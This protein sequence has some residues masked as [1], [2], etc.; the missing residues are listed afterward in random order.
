[1]RCVPQ[2]RRAMIYKQLCKAGMV[3]AHLI[4]GIKG[5]P[6]VKKIVV[7]LAVVAG[8]YFLLRPD[9]PAAP[10]VAAQS[11]RTIA[12]G[13]L[14]GLQDTENTYAWLGIPFAASTAGEGRWRKPAP[15]PA[16]QGIHEA[17]SYFPPCPQPWSVFGGV[18]GE[19]GQV[20]GSEDCLGLNIWAPDTATE[21][22][23]ALP[24]MV[25]I[26]GGSNTVGTAARYPSAELAG[27]ENVIVVTINYRLGLLGWF[28]HG[29]LRASADNAMDLSGNFGTLDTIAALEWVR[30]NIAAFGGNPENV[31]VFGESAGG[32]NVY[33]L[34]VSPLA[35][36]LF[37]RAIVQS[38]SMGSMP[39]AYGENYT[40]EENPGIV[41]SSAETVL[42]L[43][44]Q[45]E[46]A[47]DRDTAKS[48]A[49]GMSSRELE[50]FL[51]SRSIQQLLGD[52]GGSTGTYSAP[53]TFQDGYV[54]PRIALSR[55]LTDPTAYNSVPIITGSNRDE[56][57]LFMALNPKYSDLYFGLIPRIKDQSAFDNE[58][59]YYSDRWRYAAVD[60]PAD[61][62][63]SNN[64]EP[65]YA[66]RFDWDEGGSLGIVD[67][68]TALGAAHG[69]EIPFVLGGFDTFA[70]IPRLFTKGNSAARH[71]LSSGMMRYWAQFARNGDP[72]KGSRGD[73]PQWPASSA[74]VGGTM[75]LD[76]AADGGIRFSTERLQLKD[77]R[78]RLQ[79]DTLISE[80]SQ[81]CAL[82]T[83][84]FNSPRKGKEFFDAG[85][86]ALLGCESL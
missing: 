5:E 61:I 69:L 42:R 65:V 34:L 16:W 68:S 74:G 2:W 70:P 82:Y 86:Y 33:M 71:T 51:R 8:A 45:A 44:Q 10:Q 18:E 60:A 50:D 55:L 21:S 46:L 31:T 59:S 67:W 80:P 25:W 47:S 39:V 7:V 15:A 24:V 32:R 17:L 76:T 49:A 40:D 37:H 83:E 52:R 6:R 63:S 1:M 9:A 12:A 58:A 26:H 22:G 79:Q 62:I 20:S 4:Q 48:L 29:A 43:L 81:R 84:L 23:E 56:Q 64:G 78:T 53:Q 19:A 75:I 66:Y 30:D 54:I 14:V 73:L 85:E 38:G 57:K 28:R 27:R 41:N 36:G 11:L 13:E 3:F 77:F 35:K 72:G